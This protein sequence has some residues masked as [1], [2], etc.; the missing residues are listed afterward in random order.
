MWL[1]PVLLPEDLLPDRTGEIRLARE[2]LTEQDWREKTTQE[3]QS[4]FEELTS[5]ATQWGLNHAIVWSAKSYIGLWKGSRCWCPI[6]PRKE[7]GARLYLP[8]PQ[9]WENGTEETPPN[10]FEQARTEL[11]GI[12]VTLVWAWSYNMGSNPLGVTLRTEHI[13]T[14]CVRALLE[15]SWRALP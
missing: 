12:G 9:G 7:A 6:W 5:R 4:L 1:E 8:V 15:Q 14:P 2:A 3:F 10:A 13:N 11:A